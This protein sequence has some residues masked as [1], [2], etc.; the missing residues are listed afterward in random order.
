[1]S[2]IL[3]VAI[4]AKYIHTSLSVRTL[5]AYVPSVSWTEF[6]IN[7]NIEYVCAQIY[8]QKADIVMFSCYIWN[9]EFVCR[10][11]SRLKSVS[12]NI[13][14]VLGGP[15]VSFNSQHYLEYYPFVDAVIRGEGENIISEISE[16]YNLNKRGVTLR[17]SSGNIKVNPD[18]PVIQDISCIPF[19]YTELDIENNKNKLIYYESSRGCPFRCSYCLSSTSH[20]LRFRDIEIV[21][22]EL[23]FFIKHKVKIVKFT[24]RTFNADKRRTKSIIKFL[25]D[26]ADLT[27]FHFETAADLFDQETL[28][29]LASAPKGLFQLEI[30]VQSTNLQTLKAINR[31][32]DLNKI[33]DSVQ[34]I[35]DFGNIHTHLDLIA[36]LPY[37]G[38]ESFRNSF[39]D[40]FSMNPH[41]IQ[42]GFLKFLHGTQIRSQSHI[43]KFTF[44]PPYEVLS[45]EYLSY[46]D[47]LILKSIENVVDKFYNSGA[48]YGIINYLLQFFPS[49]FDLFY[50]LSVF[51]QLHGWHKIGI[52]RDKLYEII[53]EFCFE[54]NNIDNKYATD[55]LLFD[56]LK[57]N[58]PHTP[59]WAD[60]DAVGAER[61]SIL[62]P[63]F[64]EHNLPYYTNMSAKE[65]IK[66]V[67]FENI[68]DKIFLFDNLHN[69]VIDCN[70]V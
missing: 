57:N 49:P 51:Y 54:I 53:L 5:A 40:V 2:K 33:K 20:N 23:L 55:I 66:K 24:D 60:R 42:L 59:H 19:P 30:G 47:I 45:T 1:M 63:D 8:S 43:D 29:L 35:R 31:F 9:I 62:T 64:I 65:I 67:H 69:K 16:D 11:S 25:I 61:F 13:K 4:N 37:E 32:S 28:E 7:E 22:N 38:L 15:E 12:P 41:V 27:T 52:S 6:N 34:K 56:Y 3:L 68:F 21:K 70:I 46:D 14:I 26:H 44:E 18:M 48:F 50:K 39:N 58:K 36:G 10:V 17:D